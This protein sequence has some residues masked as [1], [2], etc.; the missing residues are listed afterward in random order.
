MVTGGVIVPVDEMDDG[1]AGFHPRQHSNRP[2]RLYPHRWDQVDMHTT[3][4]RFSTG[5]CPWVAN[6]A[7]RTKQ[8][9]PKVCC[10]RLEAS[11]FNVESTSTFH[12]DSPLKVDSGSNFRA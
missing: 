11:R 7:A 6:A 1:R 2:L 5:I 4:D 9:R 8:P 12:S 3:S 10:N